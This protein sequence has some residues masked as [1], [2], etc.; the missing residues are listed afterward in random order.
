MDDHM[1]TDMDETDPRRMEISLR[2][3]T[4]IP[5]FSLSILIFFRATTSPD[6]VSRALYTIPYVPSPT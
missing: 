6:F 3:D 4:G 1:P 5:S 2:P